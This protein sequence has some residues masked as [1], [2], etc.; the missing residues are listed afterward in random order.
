MHAQKYEILEEERNLF[1][2]CE[3]QC[4]SLIDD[5]KSL[6]IAPIR[7]SGHITFS[8]NH[9]L[10]RTYSMLF[11]IFYIVVTIEKNYISKIDIINLK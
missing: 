10:H 2:K 9:F 7:V 1:S 8:S 11:L 3:N 6:L 4:E 5:A